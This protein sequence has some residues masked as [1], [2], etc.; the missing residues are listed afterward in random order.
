MPQN[1]IAGDHPDHVVPNSE[2]ADLVCTLLQEPLQQPASDDAPAHGFDQDQLTLPDSLGLHADD[3]T[4]APMTCPE[5]GGPLLEHEEGQLPT[6][7]CLVGHRYSAASLEH[8]Q[9][10]HLEAVLWTAVRS[11]CERAELLRRLGRQRRVDAPGLAKRYEARSR[12]YQEQAEAVTA[13]IHHLASES[14]RQANA[15]R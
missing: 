8:E 13:A 14:T 10:H 2:L 6:F 5:C 12:T 4:L 9:A 3:A 7:N 11:L 15:A 1:A